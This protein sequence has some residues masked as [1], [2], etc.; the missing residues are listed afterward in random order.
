MQRTGSHLERASMSLH[1]KLKIIGSVICFRGVDVPPWD[2]LNAWIQHESRHHGSNTPFVS[3]NDRPLRVFKSHVKANGY[4]RSVSC[5]SN[6]QAVLPLLERSFQKSRKLFEAG[7]YI[8]QYMAQGVE[9][10]DFTN[11][12]QDLHEVILNYSTIDEYP[13]L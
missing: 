13:P 9:R 7:A 1:R 3:W 10:D 5:L 8:H 4:H 12:F 2:Q 11:A 6:G